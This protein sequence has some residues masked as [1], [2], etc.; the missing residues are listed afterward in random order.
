[1]SVIIDILLMACICFFVIRHFFTGLFLSIVTFARFILSAIIA[2]IFGSFLGNLFSSSVEDPEN[3]KLALLIGYVA[4]FV[5]TYL[6]LTLAIKLLKKVN[7]PVISIVD[8]ILGAVLGLVI[9]IL[10]VSLASVIIYTVLDIA[11]LLGIDSNAMDTYNN[12][13]VFKF[14]HDFNIFEFVGNLF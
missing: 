2:F 4:T 7:I 6:L 8:K 3:R 12:S 1:M 14:F 11:V 10:T 9:G 13:F 5:I